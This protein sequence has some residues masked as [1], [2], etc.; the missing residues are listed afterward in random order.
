VLHLAVCQTITTILRAEECWVHPKFRARISSNKIC[1]PFCSTEDLPFPLITM[2]HIFR[3]RFYCDLFSNKVQLAA[4][5][6]ACNIYCL[7]LW[8]WH[9]NCSSQHIA[10]K[11]S[12]QN[13]CVG[14]QYPAE[15]GGSSRTA[16]TAN[17]ISW[18]ACMYKQARQLIIW[19]GTKKPWHS[20]WHS[21]SSQYC[22]YTTVFYNL[23]F[24]FLQ[25]SARFM[26]RKVDSEPKQTKTLIHKGQRILNTSQS[27]R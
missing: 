9:L 19:L 16:A 23:S 10:S 17:V 11:L 13:G 20:I 12:C 22:F 15:N 25:K 26:A 7:S 2:A 6:S 4:N 21:V 1:L 27:C 8:Q 14:A 5:L 18:T 24:F 3:P